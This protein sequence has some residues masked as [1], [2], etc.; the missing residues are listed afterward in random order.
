MDLKHKG[1][2]FLIS[3]IASSNFIFF[4]VNWAVPFREEFTWPNLLRNDFDITQPETDYDARLKEGF[5]DAFDGYYDRYNDS[6]GMIVDDY[7]YDDEG[8]EIHAHTR[9]Q[10]RFA[11]LCFALS[12]ENTTYIDY[13][14]NVLRTFFR[15]FQEHTPSAGY[16][17]FGNFYWYLDDGLVDD[18]NAGPFNSVII[19]YIF[20]YYKDLMDN[21]VLNMWE[22]GAAEVLSTCVHRSDDPSY[23]NIHLLRTAGILMIGKYFNDRAAI[24]L[25]MEYFYEWKDFT[26]RYGIREYATMNYYQV[27]LKAMM[28]IWEFSPNVEF[29]TEAEEMMEFLWL[30]FLIQENNGNLGG[31][32]SRDYSGQFFYGKEML[33]FINLYFGHVYP[34]R[35]TDNS[36]TPIYNWQPTEALMERANNRTYPYYVKYKCYDIRALAYFTKNYSL[37][38]QDGVNNNREIG[39]QTIP[40]YATLNT[41]KS[42]VDIDNR[43]NTL[44]F[45]DN[46]GY[47]NLRT[48]MSQS[49]NS[50]LVAFQFETDGLKLSKS[51]GVFG[52]LGNASAV[53]NLTLNVTEIPPFTK[54]DS[55]SLNSNTTICYS[56][57]DIFIGLRVWAYL[58]DH[59]DQNDVCNITLVD[60]DESFDPDEEWEDGDA[61]ENELM[62]YLEGATAYTGILMEMDD[63]SNWSSFG[64]FSNHFYYDTNFTE[65]I[66]Q[67]SAIIRKIIAYN[68]DTRLEVHENAET[69]EITYR[70]V[71]ET[72]IDDNY[73]YY[74]PWLAIYP[75]EIDYRTPV[76]QNHRY[77]VYIFLVLSIIAPFIISLVLYELKAKNLKRNI[78]DEN[79]K[80][81]SKTKKRKKMAIIPQNKTNYF[82]IVNLAMILLSLFLIVLTILELFSW[83]MVLITIIIQQV[84][85]LS[86]LYLIN[87]PSAN[88]KRPGAFYF[89][90]ALLLSIIC[91]CIGLLVSRFFAWTIMTF[92]CLSYLSSGFVL[93]YFFNNIW[94]IDTLK[95]LKND[96]RSIRH[97]AILVLVFKIIL[98]LFALMNVAYGTLLVLDTQEFEIAAIS[99]YLMQIVYNIFATVISNLS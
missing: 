66:D 75:Q 50:M 57:G 41:N 99:I 73:I 14:N 2:I 98:L 87:E 85:Y 78:E 77:N 82:G 76:L 25:G 47:R 46:N 20:N 26:L 93:L 43:R 59:A 37:G 42:G 60:Y 40:V 6:L 16:R 70:A 64:E 68:E 48:A 89:V 28:G 22:Q 18:L 91:S 31:P 33:E 51:V 21:D 8:L 5:L 92:Y 23:T 94:S 34:H 53:Q 58:P 38:A 90:M 54:G 97:S 29:S 80:P 45:K 56:I 36:Y 86:T 96:D 72:E 83:N 10:I 39:S 67:S 65:R 12:P 4:G 84:L 79:S 95:S 71:N 55:W 9:N 13:G 35:E 3:I 69:Y 30:T 63:R 11:L 62:L 1:L 88:Q 49:E 52:F 74:S 17:T 32:H 44:F 61:R 27:I 19:G 81:R 24:K 15:Q 7:D